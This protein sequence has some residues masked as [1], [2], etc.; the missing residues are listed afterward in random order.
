ML[1]DTD[2]QAASK[3]HACQAQDGS[4]MHTMWC[5]PTVLTGAPS[6]Y[7]VVRHSCASKTY[8]SQANILQK[9]YN[10]LP[11]YCVNLCTEF[12]QCWPTLIC[13][14]RQTFQ[15]IVTK[16]WCS[17][18]TCQKMFACSWLLQLMEVD[19]SITSEALLLDFGC[20]KLFKITQGI[21]RNVFAAD[22]WWNLE[23]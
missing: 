16:C 10:V 21:S 2:A 7:N 22:D 9:A 20:T 3:T 23:I 18:Q 5:P 13:K 11:T 1:A 19:M 4:R 12:I 8:A 6:S 17:G 14:P 15:T